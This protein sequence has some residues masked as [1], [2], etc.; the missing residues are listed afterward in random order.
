MP[1]SKPNL[2]RAGATALA[3]SADSDWIVDVVAAAARA[4][5]APADLLGDFPQWLLTAARTAS[6]PG[7]SALLE[8]QDLGR[9]AAERGTP[10]NVAV[11]LYLSA[12]LGLWRHLPQSQRARGPRDVH[13]AA[14]AVLRVTNDAIEALITGHQIARQQM[15]RHQQTARQEFIDDL[16]RGDADVAR[17][18]Q[19]A[20][21]F[22]LD[23]GAAHHVVLAAPPRPGAE[24]D[25]TALGL[26]RYIVD[27]F[28]DREVLV[29]TKD[30]RIVVIVPGIEQPAPDATDAT[31]QVA[32]QVSARLGEPTGAITRGDV[33]TDRDPGRGGT[34]GGSGAW[35]VAAGRPYRGSFGIA[36]SYEEARDTLEIADR[37][38]LDAAT[39][40]PGQLLVH[41]VIGRDQAAIV[42]LVSTVLGPL[43]EARGGAA[44]LLATLEAYFA[45][46]ETATEAARRL[47]MS[48]RAVTYRLDR[49]ARLTGY[50]VGRPDE[51]FVLRTAVEGARGL[52]WPAQ[53]LP[54]S[55]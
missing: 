47:H 50:D 23:L 25:R 9:Q 14:E 22:G 2:K 39:L 55:S 20:E 40:T 46:S 7:R 4:S 11:S 43:Q 5:G 53:P 18:V 3:D 10:A 16:L 28:G 34:A 45:S 49:I 48:V 15:I 33:G 26:E 32:R 21:P 44:P 8:V 36:R 54:G 30:G 41:R 29:G 19:R 52:D 12:A 42:D 17:M 37:L 31:L 6:R 51:R 35:Q 1:R 38:H 13:A 24:V 27:A